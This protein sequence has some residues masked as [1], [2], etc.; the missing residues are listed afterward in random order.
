MAS[1]EI[2]NI[3][4]FS[5]TSDEEILMI[6]MFNFSSTYDWNLSYDTDINL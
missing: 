6:F 5:I 1:L 2:A 3:L 4:W